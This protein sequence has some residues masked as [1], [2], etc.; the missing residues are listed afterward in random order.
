MTTLEKVTLEKQLR[1]KTSELQKKKVECDGLLTTTRLLS[2][3]SVP[4]AP[5]VRPKTVTFGTSTAPPSSG[6][7]L[8][9]STTPRGT[10]IGGSSPSSTSFG[11]SAGLS[12]GL[13]SSY[14]AAASSSASGSG[15]SGGAGGGGGD[16]HGGPGHG[17]GYPFGS[18]SAT[19]FRDS[20]PVT[21]TG[22]SL[23]K[24]L[25]EASK[26]IKCSLSSTSDITD[27]ILNQTRL[28]DKI[29]QLYGDE[30]P[31]VQCAIARHL[32][33]D[34]IR[35]DGDHVYEEMSTDGRFGL[36]R[37][38]DRL[39]ALSFPAPHSSL[40]NGFRKLSQTHPK[41]QTIVEYS[42]MFKTYI[43]MLE[44]DLKRQST[45]FIDGLANP[46]VRSS[47]R[48]HNLER[49]EFQDIVS[50]AVSIAN[51]TMNERGGGSAAANVAC[52]DDTWDDDDL[53]LKVFD[54]PIKKYFTE[55]D[56]HNMRGLCW[57][58]GGTHKS[59]LCRKKSCAFC[60][61]PVSQVRHY[62]LLCERAPLDF[63]NFLG[64]REMAKKVKADAVRIASD[65]DFAFESDGLED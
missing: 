60:Q 32:L 6:T 20:L 30:S 39:F 26:L 49:M 3:T 5:D 65:F 46:D 53:S 43:R 56:K 4:P 31:E 18:D 14:A 61:L 12:S 58:C 8:G 13:S 27:W 24:V 23:N 42:R 15:G 50:L 38:W 25:L 33:T 57:N 17:R 48:R 2:A 7:W 29:T 35:S 1:E 40:E 55:A 22:S 45:R 59:A 37:F 63:K 11:A 21:R 36:D 41:R 19:R 44:M 9:G 10:F 62:S 54:T 64:R 28:K 52:E 16:D 34:H 51:Q 47:L